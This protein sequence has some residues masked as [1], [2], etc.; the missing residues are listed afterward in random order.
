[1][2]EPQLNAVRHPL[3]VGGAGR[4]GAGVNAMAREARRSGQQCVPTEVNC[5][6]NPAE[7][8]VR[9]VIVLWT[10]PVWVMKGTAAYPR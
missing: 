10:S 1:M 5:N 3:L 4:N 6:I 8:A 2:R 9:A 7:I